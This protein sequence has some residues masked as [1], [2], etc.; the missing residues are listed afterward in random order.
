M[1]ISLNPKQVVSSEKLLVSQV[2]ELPGW[3]WRK[4]CSPIKENE[5]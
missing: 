4:G 1:A 2:G 3:L 5:K